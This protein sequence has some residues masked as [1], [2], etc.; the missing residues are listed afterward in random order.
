MASALSNLESDPFADLEVPAELDES[1]RRHREHLA[2]LIAT[3]RLAGVGEAHIEE[4]VSVI[5]DSYKLELI[6]AI[7][8]MMA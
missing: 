4:S 8:R 1:L 7:K 6:R 2:R 5:V 3:L